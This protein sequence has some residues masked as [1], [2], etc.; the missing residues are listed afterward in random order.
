MLPMLLGF[1]ALFYFI[2][3][4][5]DMKREKSLK[6]MRE[7]LKKND[8]IVTSGGIFGVVTN[9]QRETNEVTIKVDEATNAKLRVTLESIAKVL[10][11]A[12]P[13]GGAPAGSSS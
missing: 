10:V 5:P 8:R 12:T 3:L 11:E 4:R 1:V 7:S 9:V 2:F 6:S 13:E